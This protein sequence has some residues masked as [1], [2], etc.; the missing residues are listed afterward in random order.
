MASIADHIRK[1]MPDEE[2]ASWAAQE[3]PQKSFK[4]RRLPPFQSKIV[5]LR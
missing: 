1:A 5:L 4:S 2:A 3:G